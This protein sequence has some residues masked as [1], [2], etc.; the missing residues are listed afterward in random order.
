MPQGRSDDVM[1]YDCV[2]RSYTTL[3]YNYYY[4]S[5]DTLLIQENFNQN[6]KISKPHDESHK[7]F[8]S[9]F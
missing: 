1:F 8:T 2:I 9:E 6:R 7:S 4:S 3:M 5:R